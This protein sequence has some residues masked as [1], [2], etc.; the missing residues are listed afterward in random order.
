MAVGSEGAHAQFVGEGEGLAVMGWDLIEVREITMRCNVA[1]ETE[2]IRLVPPFLVLTG[3]RQV[4]LGEGIHLIQT[5]SRKMCLSEGKSA[6][7]YIAYSFR[8]HSLL[9]GPR[10]Q[11]STAKGLGRSGSTSWPCHSR[12]SRR[13]SRNGPNTRFCCSGMAPPSLIDRAM[14]TRS[15]SEE[16]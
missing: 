9:H 4:V 6:E 12:S 10:K 11:R 2:G 8:R 15:T 1:G 16:F 13:S 14:H 3:E 5:P 7:H